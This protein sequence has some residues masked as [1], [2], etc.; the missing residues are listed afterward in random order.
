M[1]I[2]ITAY[3]V[4]GSDYAITL[5]RDPDRCPVCEVSALP[6]R[7]KAGMWIRHGL[8]EVVYRCPNQSC[9][10]TFIAA[11]DSMRAESYL[12]L[13][14]TYPNSFDEHDS[15]SEVQKI[16]PSFQTI[17]NQ[18]LE[19]E[20]LGLNEIAGMG[21]RKSLEFLIKDYCISKNPGKEETIKKT[22]LGSCIQ[23]FVTD[24]NV[25]ACAERA[26][27]LGNDETHYTRQW[28]SHDIEDLKRLVR[29]TE[30]WIASEVATATYL[31]TMQKPSK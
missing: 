3:D 8:V 11:Y 5:D 29:L 17:Y 22:L 15:P 16:S 14:R 24:T 1:P 23:N 9:L 7:E 10:R 21:F 26:T 18:A 28:Q 31:S 13:R 6:K 30:N 4:N 27:W 20:S 12:Y 19:A 2:H 25:K